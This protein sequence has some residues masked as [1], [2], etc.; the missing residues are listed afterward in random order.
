MTKKYSD[1]DFDSE[2]FRVVALHEGFYRF[3]HADYPIGAAIRL[4][5][6]WKYVIVPPGI[7]REK[8]KIPRRAVLILR[9][10]TL[11]ST[12]AM[13]CLAILVV[14]VV[15]LFKAMSAGVSIFRFRW[16]DR[17]KWS[18]IDE[19]LLWSTTLLHV[20]QNNLPLSSCSSLYCLAL[21]ATVIFAILKLLAVGGWVG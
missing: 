14:M 5:L 1:S 9:R 6:I 18:F 19:F 21:S 20:V 3:I 7:C 15:C 12:A 2:S 17:D 13:V 11:D 8:V 16:S 4:L 10:A